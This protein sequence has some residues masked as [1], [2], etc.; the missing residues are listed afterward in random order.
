MYCKVIL[1]GRIGTN[2]EVKDGKNT[3]FVNFNLATSEFYTPKGGGDR[4]EKT[5]W[6]K[7]V[8]F[9]G[10]AEYIGRSGIDKGDLVFVEGKLSNNVIDLDSKKIKTTDVIAS[11]VKPMSKTA[12]RDR[13]EDDIPF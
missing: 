10:L 5:E 13:Q 9:G 11:I 2:V 1:I 6:H 7:V 8:A 3:K 12:S 4:V